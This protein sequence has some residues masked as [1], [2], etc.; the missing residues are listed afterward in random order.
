MNGELKRKI[1]M[2]RWLNAA[3]RCAHAPARESAHVR[4]LPD[5]RDYALALAVPKATHG[6]CSASSGGCMDRMSNGAVCV[7]SSAH[8]PAL[9]LA[10]GLPSFHVTGRALICLWDDGTPGF[11]KALA[12]HLRVENRV[13]CMC[14]SRQVEKVL[15]GLLPLSGILVASRVRVTG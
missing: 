13:A 6:V 1:V 5:R 14:T 8:R 2:R 7:S 12:L 15:G 4:I 9:L 3:R 11:G 10:R